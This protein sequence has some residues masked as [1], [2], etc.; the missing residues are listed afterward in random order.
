MVM[1]ERSSGH[2][3]LSRPWW[4][5]VPFPGFEEGSARREGPGSLLMA[6][7]DAYLLEEYPRILEVGVP[8]SWNIYV[9]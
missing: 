6:C 4:V 7:L 2:L 8:K 9:G 3:V 5:R 1:V